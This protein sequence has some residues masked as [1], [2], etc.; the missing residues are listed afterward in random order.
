[1]RVHYVILILS[2]SLLA[3]CGVESPADDA[4]LIAASG[5]AYCGER[6]YYINN[7][8][9]MYLGKDSGESAVLCFDPLCNHGFLDGGGIDGN[10]TCPAYIGNGQKLIAREENGVTAIYYIYLKSEIDKKTLAVKNVYQLRC[11]DAGDLKISVVTEITDNSIEK[12][13]LYGD[14]FY[15]SLY[16]A[17]D[18]RETNSNLYSVP[19]SGGNPRLVLEGTENS[20]SLVGAWDG[21]LYWK[22]AFGTDIYR[23]SP[24]FTETEIILS[25]IRSDCFAYGGYIYYFKSEG[26]PVTVESES[27]EGEFDPNYSIKG[28]WTIYP[29]NLYRVGAEA[30]AQSELVYAGMTLPFVSGPDNTANYWLDAEN[31]VF[32]TAPSDPVY[33]G[34]IVWRDTNITPD[35]AAQLGLT[36][37]DLLTCVLSSTNGRVVAID[38][39]TL[40]TSDVY[41][42]LKGDI[43][44]I[45]G[46]A[47]GILAVKYK[48]TDIDRNKSAA[49]D[50]R[51]KRQRADILHHDFSTADIN[52]GGLLKAPT[53]VC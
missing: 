16:S 47:G 14:N 12:F 32:Y 23:S 24:D 42:G 13:W 45:Y 35:A 11:L 43:F 40:K 51:A 39:N 34:Y 17:D 29:W 19:A 46:V 53:V 4:P 49:R 26:D 9:L 18:E 10:T 52:Y 38:L 6:L 44:S 33:K 1:M 48:V 25:D 31:G 5:G 7:M 50:R 15:L 2:V 22:Y 8:H 36:D 20:P 3:S 27:V 28:P 37:T 21:R 41:T 30:G